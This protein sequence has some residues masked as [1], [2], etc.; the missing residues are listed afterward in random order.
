MIN[1]LNLGKNVYQAEINNVKG[2]NINVYVPKI[3]KQYEVRVDGIRCV[4]VVRD[5]LNPNAMRLL[6]GK[7]NFKPGE[8][9]DLVIDQIKDNSL[10]INQIWKYEVQ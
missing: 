3:K 10:N 2:K 7:C 6:E 1:S 8:I 5:V 9:I 4:R